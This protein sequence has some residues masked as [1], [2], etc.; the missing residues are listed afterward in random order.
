MDNQAT[1]LARQ[2]VREMEEYGYVLVVCPKCKKNPDVSITKRGVI[3]ERMSVSCECRYV[4][5]GE[6]YL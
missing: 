4:S 2:A 5:A 6:I 1:K 3:W